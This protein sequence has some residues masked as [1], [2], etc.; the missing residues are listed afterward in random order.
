MG[1]EPIPNAGDDARAPGQAAGVVLLPKK[2]FLSFCEFLRCFFHFLH[3]PVLRAIIHRVTFIE[4][5]VTSSEHFVF[6]LSEHRVTYPK[7]PSPLNS[8]WSWPHIIQYTTAFLQ[9]TFTPPSLL[10]S[11]YTPPVLKSTI[12]PPS[13]LHSYY[14]PPVLQSTITTPSSLH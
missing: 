8:V 5:S 12:R 1:D 13:S 10:H 11:F 6:L 3:Q 7:R 2:F 14:T 4:H 9:S